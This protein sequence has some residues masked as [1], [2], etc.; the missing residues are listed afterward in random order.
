MYGW[1]QL[2]KEVFHILN[3]PRSWQHISI[4][5]QTAATARNRIPTDLITIDT[6]KMR[7]PYYKSQVKIH[8]PFISF[9]INRE[10][11]IIQIYL[12]ICVSTLT[13]HTRIIYCFV[14]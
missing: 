14:I 5:Q 7:N 13:M 6:F 10:F 9:N 12:Q 1:N 11:K 4:L 2:I 3:K 8:S